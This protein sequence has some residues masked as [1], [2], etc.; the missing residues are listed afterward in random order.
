MERKDHFLQRC[1]VCSSVRYN[2]R[3]HMFVR[4]A[5]KY[6]ILKCDLNRHQIYMYIS[7][8]NASKNIKILPSEIEEA[9]EVLKSLKENMVPCNNRLPFEFYKT[10]WHLLGESLINS[11][12]P[13]FESGRIL[14][15][16]Q[17]QAIITLI[18]KNP[19]T[20]SSK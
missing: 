10:F 19:L 5:N 8:I 16:S 11:F 15:T 7:C 13:A 2:C 12:N 18:N 9:T 6:L 4:W 17:R 20:I 14:S 3:G 1:L